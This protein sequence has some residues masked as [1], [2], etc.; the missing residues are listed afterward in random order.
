MPLQNRVD[1]FSKIHAVPDRGMFTGNRGI[2]HD[3][4]T[5]T[6]RKTSWA[7]DG[8]VIC[9]LAPLPGREK[10]TRLMNKGRW[11]E[12]FFLDELTG[13]A[14]GHR[15]CFACRKAE[16]SSFRGAAGVAKIRDLNPAIH[17]D[18]KPRLRVY[19][20]E[21]TPPCQPAELP[22]G[23]MFADAGQAFVKW[24]DAAFQWSFSGYA[25]QTV[26]PKHASQLTPQITCTALANG[27]QPVI[28]PSLSK[29]ID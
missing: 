22:N 12:L 16:A 5:Q 19:S 3:H 17:A 23:A 20:P 26:L 15:P 13:L 8:W 29:L 2:L 7:T 9:T 1:P 27:Y 11:T 24:H 6:L 21:P 25:Q 10:R 28:H 4:K 18:M 14:A